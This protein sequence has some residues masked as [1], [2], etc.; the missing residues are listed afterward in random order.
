MKLK[1]MEVFYY[2]F[3]PRV[4]TFAETHEDIFKLPVYEDEYL[5][6]KRNEMIEQEKEIE[7]KVKEYKN[8][9]A[10]H[11]KKT[12]KPRDLISKFKNIDYK[13]E[14]VVNNINDVIEND[15]QTFPKKTKKDKKQK[16]KGIKTKKAN[17]TKEL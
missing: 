8:S 10:L 16:M 15:Q 11:L 13:S 2:Y 14:K 12:N 17:K 3:D 4:R 1:R 9:I 6:I 7:K 5:R